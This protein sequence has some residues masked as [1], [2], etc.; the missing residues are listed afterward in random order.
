MALIRNANAATIAREAIVLDLGDLREQGERMIRAARAEAE[1]VV[2]D[3]RTE[4]GRIL[5]G[6]CEE[7]RAEGHERGLEQGRITGREEA[8]GQALDEHRERLARVESA[9]TGALGEFAAR[10]E[11]LVQGALRDVLRLAVTIAE[12]VAKRAIELDPRVVEHQLA[13]VLAVVVRPTEL[14]VRINPRDRATVE[15]ALPGLMAAMPAVRCAEIVDD[16]AVERGGCIART[17]GEAGSGDAGGGEI[18]ARIETQL[19][20]IVEAILPGTTR[21]GAGRPGLEGER[22]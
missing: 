21:P 9:W 2:S 13:A 18:D 15:R 8:K 4:R 20:R 1:R 12:R 22:A 11:D 19:D 6:A 14:V 16:A 5:A 7:G 17:R 10:R 3:A